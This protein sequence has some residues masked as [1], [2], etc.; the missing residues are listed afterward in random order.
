MPRLETRSEREH[1]LKLMLQTQAGREFIHH[2]YERLFLA[3]DELIPAGF[4]V[5]ENLVQLILA[6]EY[7]DEE[8]TSGPAPNSPR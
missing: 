1:D 8:E 2:L 4:I 3:P 6:K 7:P 5:N